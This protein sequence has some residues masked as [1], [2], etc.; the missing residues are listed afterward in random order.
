MLLLLL[1][2]AGCL[3]RSPAYYAPVWSPDGQ[4]LYYVAARPDGTLSVG[5]L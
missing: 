4:K 5:R 3:W 1:L 2:L